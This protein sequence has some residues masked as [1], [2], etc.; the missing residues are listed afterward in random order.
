[1]LVNAVIAPTQPSLGELV[2]LSARIGCLS[3]GGPA[4]QIALMHREIVEERS[5]VSEDEYLHALNLCHL[6]PGPEAQQLAIW[7][8]WKL[9]GLKGGL[10]AGLLFVIPGALVI[11]ALSVLYGFAAHLDWFAAL[12]LGIKAA[13][14]AVVVQA[15][16]RVAGRAL[17]TGFKRV[18]AAAAFLALFALSAP[19]PLV[20][21]TAGLLGAVASVLRPD[22]LALKP[23]SDVPIVGPQPWRQ[24]LAAIAGFGALWAAPMVLIALTLGQGHVL[25]QIGVFFSKLAVVTFGGAYAVLAYMA[26]QAVEN[27]GWLSAGEMADGLGLAET[28]PGPLIMVTQFVGYLAAFRAPVPFTPLLAGM[29]G[30]AL[31]T[32]VT[33]APCFLW[34]FALAPWMERLERAPRLKGALAAI[35]AAVVGVIANLSLWFALHVLFRDGQKVALGPLKFEAP[36][37][38][39]LDWRAA[40]LA[41]LSAV[42]IFAAKWGVIRVL[43]LAALGGFLLQI[44]VPIS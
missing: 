30:A 34:I 37:V 12:F 35:T 14:L 40:L 19:F 9:H 6:L 43:A 5:W 11:L 18:I 3:F 4:G 32:W 27:Y 28:T 41:A 39:S 13:V 33:F 23:A 17:N 20:L 29:I 8:G 7:I 44:M 25:W 22:W 15:L 1:M 31:T 36:L 38:S 24:S 26:Q 10:A 2:R 16:L 42:L 21:L